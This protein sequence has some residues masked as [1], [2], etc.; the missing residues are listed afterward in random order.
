LLALSLKLLTRSAP[1]WSF[2]TL[3]GTMMTP[4]GLTSPSAG[5]VDASVRTFVSCGRNAVA[6]VAE[7]LE[8]V[9][10]RGGTSRRP[11]RAVAGATAPSD[12]DQHGCD[13]SDPDQLAG[14]VAMVDARELHVDV[15][16][17][18]ALSELSAVH[19]RAD[20]GALPGKVVLLPAAT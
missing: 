18:L 6:A 11:G 2:P 4:Y 17:R 15:A 10:T 13:K 14:L 16:E 3:A 9:G 7:A 12:R 19:A 8:E 1:A 20:A 5:T